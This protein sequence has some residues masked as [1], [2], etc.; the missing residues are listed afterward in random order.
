[1]TPIKRG[2]DSFFGLFGGGFNHFTK[3]AGGCIDLH[4]DN[5]PIVTVD[6]KRH[7]TTTFTEEA[8][9]VIEKHSKNITNPL[10]LVVSYTAAHDPL[11]AEKRDIELCDRKVKTFRRKMF[12]A[13]VAGMDRGIFKIVETLKERKLWD[14]TIFIWT[15]DNGGFPYSGGF[16]HP[17]RGYKSSAWEG[18]VRVPALIVAPERFIGSGRS[19]TFNKLFHIADWVPTILGF[20]DNELAR[21]TKDGSSTSLLISKARELLESRYSKTKF[22]GVNQSSSLLSAGTSSK[23]TQNQIGSVDDERMII[24]Q[25][26]IFMNISAARK[27]DWK[28]MMGSPGLP[29]VYFEPPQ[30]NDFRHSVEGPC[31]YIALQFQVAEALAD[32][33]EEEFGYLPIIFTVLQYVIGMQRV[34]AMDYLCGTSYRNFLHHDS[35]Q[36]KSLVSPSIIPTLE[37]SKSEGPRVYLFNLANDPTES[38]NL[39]YEKPELVKKLY[40]EFS[41]IIST[42]PMQFAGDA[43]DSAA[44]KD[45]MC[46]SWISNDA[47][48]TN[49]PTVDKRFF[50]FMRTKLERLIM[51]VTVVGVVMVLAT[52]ALLFFSLRFLYRQ[53]V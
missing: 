1:M 35:R 28:L 3:D 7:A 6:T 33:W 42:A 32:R 31:T 39:A 14:D 45:G 50:I 10:F 40:A 20:I 15:S 18:G 53:L 8:V 13:M 5:T 2:F 36:I 41:E 43:I 21:I 11:L 27:G 46:K 26:D 23:T 22:D 30:G 44:P 4:R 17:Y 34:V 29:W 37:W 48:L 19:R 9:E 25:H 49:Y 12:C 51:I 52:L 38:K 47:D 24:L 16:N